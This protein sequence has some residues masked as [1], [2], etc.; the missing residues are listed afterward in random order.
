ML[1]WL[2]GLDSGALGLTPVATTMPCIQQPSIG[3]RVKTEAFHFLQATSLILAAMAPE[4]VKKRA[5]PLQPQP[6]KQS[7]AAHEGPV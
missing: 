3:V 7:S 2:I 5:V 4:L 6:G 1:P